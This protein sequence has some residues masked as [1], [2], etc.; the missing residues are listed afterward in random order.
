LHQLKDTGERLQREV[1]RPDNSR[2]Y[3]MQRGKHKTTSNKIQYTL[4]SSESGSPNIESPEYT[5]TPE[6]QEGDLS[7]EDNRVL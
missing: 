7:C 1:S 6:N 2:Y 5:N 3:Q 4:A